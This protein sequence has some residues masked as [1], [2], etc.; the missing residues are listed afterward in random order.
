[1]RRFV[2]N[3]DAAN[4]FGTLSLFSSGWFLSLLLDGTGSLVNQHIIATFPFF[5]VRQ[6]S[7]PLPPLYLLL[8][9]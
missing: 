3:A 5:F 4:G 7:D 9:F 8:T 6:S 1:V 2:W